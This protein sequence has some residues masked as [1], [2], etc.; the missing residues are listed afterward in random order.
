VPTLWAA[1]LISAA[2]RPPPIL[3]VGGDE[4]G[5]PNGVKRWV[6]EEEV[7]VLDRELNLIQIFPA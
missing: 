3:P 7:W 6:V 2:G 1:S 5:H 4:T